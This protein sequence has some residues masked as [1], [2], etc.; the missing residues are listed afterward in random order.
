MSEEFP[1]GRPW[2]VRQGK[3]RPRHNSPEWQQ[4]V[5]FNHYLLAMRNAG[6]S[7]QKIADKHGLSE[8]TVFVRSQKA[9]AQLLDSDFKVPGAVACEKNSIEQENSK[10]RAEV[11]RLKKIIRNAA[12]AAM[13]ATA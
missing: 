10:L 9:R 11:L 7:C 2:F 5:R 4:Q 3:K 12:K 13:E 6:D 1:P 8:A